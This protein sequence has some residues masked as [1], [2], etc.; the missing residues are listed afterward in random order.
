VGH[1]QQQQQPQHTPPQQNGSAPGR[2]GSMHGS[3]YGGGPSPVV[4]TPEQLQRYLVRLA[5]AICAASVARE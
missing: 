3:P 4:T 2:L 5:N 1:E